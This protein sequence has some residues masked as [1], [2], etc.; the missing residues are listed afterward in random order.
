MRGVGIF[1]CFV[2]VSHATREISPT[3]VGTAGAECSTVNGKETNPFFPESGV[4]GT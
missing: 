2:D 3:L 1:L 4:R